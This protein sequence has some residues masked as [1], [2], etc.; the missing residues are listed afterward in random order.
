[1]D[2]ANLSFSV[3]PSGAKTGA[4]SVVKSLD[5]IRRA[6][7]QSA[8]GFR[9][10]ESAFAKMVQA[11]R[12]GLV[13][14]G[15]G[16]AAMRTASLIKQ[17]IELSARYNE[18]GIGL[19]RVAANVGAS[20]G[21][22]VALEESLRRTGIS[23]IQSRQSIMSMV[24]AN[25]DLTQATKLAKVA[26]DAAVVGQVNSSDAL[27]RII[28][29]LQTAQPEML[30]TLGLTVNFE[31]AYAK[32][33]ASLNV[34][35]DALTNEQKA[36]A[37][38]NATMEAGGKI[39]GLYEASMTSASKQ[40]R[41]T[42]RYVQDLQVRLGSLFQP[43]YG[44]A[45]FAYADALKYM[46]KNTD[47]VIVGITGIAAVL[48]ASKMAS[49]LTSAASALGNFANKFTDLGQQKIAKPLLAAQDQAFL[50]L[51][52]AKAHV[53]LAAAQRD[54]ALAESKGAKTK[55]EKAA[56]TLN[57]IAAERAYTAALATET[58]AQVQANVA[59]NA[60]SAVF[61]KLT[62]STMA[63]GAA[64]KA[65]A[66]LGGPIGVAMTLASVGM[67]KFATT[68]S[69]AS[70]FS[71][72][73][74]ENLQLYID[75]VKEAEKNVTNL[76]AAEANR[77]AQEKA[78]QLRSVQT[79]AAK[80]KDEMG[81]SSGGGMFGEAKSAYDGLSLSLSVK[82]QKAQFAIQQIREEFKKTG[83]IDKYRQSLA[84]IFEKMG[85]LTASQEAYRVKLTEQAVSYKA[86][87][88]WMDVLTGKAPALTEAV[89]K[90][91][92]AFSMT[93]LQTAALTKSY[94]D[95]NDAQTKLTLAQRVGVATANAHEVAAGKMNM[96]LTE[97]EKVLGGTKNATYMAAVAQIEFAEKTAKS[98]K[99]FAT[100][101][102]AAKVSKAEIDA[103]NRATQNTISGFT[104]AATDAEQFS[105]Q[106]DEMREAAKKLGQQDAFEK[107]WLPAMREAF[108]QAQRKGV[109]D[110]SRSLAAQVT[111]IDRSTASIVARAN[112]TRAGGAA[113]ATLT[114]KEEA[115]NAVREK[116]LTGI[117]AVIQYQ[118]IYTALM[119]KAA[120]ERSATYAASVKETADQIR[121][122]LEEAA[123]YE[124]GGE[125][126][127]NFT[128]KIAILNLIKQGRTLFD[129]TLIVSQLEDIERRIDKA[130]G[131]ASIMKEAFLEASRGIQRTFSTAIA[132]MFNGSL[133]DAKAYGDQM[134]DL[135]KNIGAQIAAA[136][137]MKKLGIP[138]MLKQIENG[139][140]GLQDMMGGGMLKGKGA[141]TKGAA[142][143]VVGGAVGYST[144]NAALGALS[145]AGAGFAVAGPIGAAA[146]AVAGLVGGMI[147]HAKAMREEQKRVEEVTRQYKRSME[148]FA[149]AFIQPLTDV[150]KQTKELQTWAKEQASIAASALGKNAKLG[151]KDTELTP[152]QLQ[153]IAAY[154]DLIA[155]LSFGPKGIEK[156]QTFAAQIRETAEVLSKAYVKT[157]EAR[158]KA[159]STFNEELA[160]RAASTVGNEAEAD[161]IR[162]R[163]RHQT[164][165]DD[166][167]L[168]GFTATTIA[169]LKRVQALEASTIALRRAQEMERERLDFAID[170]TARLGKLTGNTE[171]SA[172]AEA[173]STRQSD[174]RGADDLLKRGVI[175]Q[176]QYDEFMKLI[177]QA[178]AGALEER[179]QGY[180]DRQEDLGVRR[181]AGLGADSAAEDLAFRLSQERELRDAMKD[182]S[183]EGQLYANTLKEVQ[184]IEKA[185]RDAAKVKA[186]AA[187]I[188][189][190]ADAQGDLS[191]RALVASGKSAEAETLAFRLAQERE[192]R[193]AMKDTTAEGFAYAA[194]LREVQAAEV[195]ARNAAIEKANVELG[196]S[197]DV[198]MLRAQ[199]KGGE[200]DAMQLSI[201]RSR[202]IADA[203]TAEL[204]ARLVLL[205]AMEDEARA[206]ELS[207]A[208]QADYNSI[209]VET[210]QLQGRSAD[211]AR[212]EFDYRQAM[213]LDE[214]NQKFQLGQ[215]LKA[216]YDLGIG[217]I[218]LRNTA[219]E[220]SQAAQAQKE[221]FAP[222]SS[223]MWESQSTN[224]SDETTTI[225]DGTVSMRSG[226]SI[227]ETTSLQLVDY[228][229]SQLAVQRR[230]LAV[231]E[232]R[233]TSPTANSPLSGTLLDRTLGQNVDSTALLVSGV[234]T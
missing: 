189:A 53:V 214:L 5:D 223:S 77:V 105:A 147:G 218:G 148:D 193:E 52:E 186:E 120:A 152:S 30:R 102:N 39:T 13:M 92:D 203:A 197:I 137:V 123:A 78:A 36:Q 150:Q 155:S 84:S 182:T 14:L 35:Q 99:G 45:V 143:V 28:Y 133:K 60:A 146:G 11:T 129:A 87:T 12:Q 94:K 88:Q 20:K 118:R 76:T 124:K 144:G 46:A 212:V 134:I 51:K 1:M 192:M 211:A 54:S 179:K 16:F 110:L 130:K 227:T 24:Q 10:Q 75:K 209:L 34:G 210:L 50:V 156:W 208:N 47:L 157:A 194:S 142:G 22:I 56:A 188:Q 138:D 82:G 4:A 198:R 25:M 201:D 93:E 80:Q 178:F 141:L 3:D 161:A 170:Y 119:Q 59:R 90:V 180:R 18:L 225:G 228:A 29:G 83:D 32:M 44:L 67:A 206:R 21:Q 66:F 23:A 38:L 149:A 181:L 217:L 154:A 132:D 204:K 224:R 26:Q 81:L 151:G 114:A 221:S 43:A 205:H 86:V 215:I 72:S 177:N 48:G 37:R 107:K 19:T 219:F 63:A 42:E 40:L 195:A 95:T 165:L 184:E 73:H 229:S 164:E 104:R 98:E 61:H 216:T 74:A 166:A 17:T 111:N 31:Q 89:K 57:V 153:E 101:A 139:T 97:F 62:L 58:G 160:A 71:Q 183:H 27:Q 232:A 6:A 55:Q 191:V 185:A 126:V 115:T 145:G 176:Q 175:S 131:A 171:L 174:T 140:F 49:M 8:T 103:F 136:F 127:T 231:L 234:I 213:F 162:L 69:E 173:E 128:K 226:G 122:G 207:R 70:K 65:M 9:Q 96:T 167:T 159:E 79:S 15:A 187:R 121:N 168:K 2:A 33:A 199:G 135:F 222:S 196:Q 41:S 202:E 109:E 85:P 112:A 190:A 125:A 172:I 163:L 7:A 100:L 108:S 158:A 64:S 169:E 233:D 68:T 113:L 200:A 230:I 116:G 106:L 91:T 117:V 220:R